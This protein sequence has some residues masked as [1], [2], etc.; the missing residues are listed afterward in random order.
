MYA[1]CLL[2][3]GSMLNLFY[4]LSIEAE[5]LYQANRTVEALEAM[6]EG[7]A[8]VERCK[9]RWGVRRNATPNALYFTVPSALT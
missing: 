9:E 2:A 1:G 7:E 5:V 4:L 8:M 3:T 6:S